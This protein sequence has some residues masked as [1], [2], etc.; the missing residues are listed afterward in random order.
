MRSGCRSRTGSSAVPERFAPL[1]DLYRRSAAQAGHEGDD[2]RVSVAAVGLVAPTKPEAKE[3]FYPGW[4]R[5]FAQTGE[6][7]GWA[8]PSRAQF[9]LLADAPGAYYV[10]D[11]DDVA[12][13]IVDL[14]QHMGHM[15]HFLQTDIGG[16]PHEHYLE[17]IRLLATEVKPR[18]ERL[19]ERA[20]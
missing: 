12:E 14:R 6:I 3:R 11:P 16:L 18:V 4:Q 1:A 10:G 9:D 2:I 19:L 13:R 17:S 8:P 15:R 20:R 5:I 7:R